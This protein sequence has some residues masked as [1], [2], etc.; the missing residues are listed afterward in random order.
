[1]APKNLLRNEEVVGFNGLSD[2]IMSLL[3]YTC[4]AAGEQID[5]IGRPAVDRGHAPAPT[6][7]RRTIPGAGIVG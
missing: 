3:L 4:T 1:M 6:E 7:T 5:E 2:L